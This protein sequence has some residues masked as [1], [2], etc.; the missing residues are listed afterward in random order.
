MFCGGVSG[1]KLSSSSSSS[2]SALEPR[3]RA[4]ESEL[5]AEGE[6]PPGGETAGKDTPRVVQT[7]IIVTK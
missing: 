4:S 2:I 6:E 1:A 3:L 5:Q 7:S